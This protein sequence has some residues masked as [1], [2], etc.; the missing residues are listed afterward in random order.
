MVWV[1]FTADYDFKPKRAVT[2]GY[3]AGMVLNVPAAAA[4]AAVAASKAVMM[5]KASKDAEPVEIT[6]DG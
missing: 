6:D 2:I 3:R 4:R 5:R 1:K